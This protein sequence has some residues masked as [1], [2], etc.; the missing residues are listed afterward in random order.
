MGRC[1]V[2]ADQVSAG[3]H[4]H[5]AGVRPGDLLQLING[6]PPAGED[7]DELRTS[8][9]TRVRDA[10]QHA[11]GCTIRFLRGAA[12][13]E[14]LGMMP[15]AHRWVLMGRPL[16]RYPCEHKE[17]H[18]VKDRDTFGN[19]YGQLQACGLGF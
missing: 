9:Q 2:F 11:D 18:H 3:S 10:L 8:T 19:A 16:Y 4:G 17:F 13:L 14:P 7:D 6:Q 5:L 12:L 1:L 15:S